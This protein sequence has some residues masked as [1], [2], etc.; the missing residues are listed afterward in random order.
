[1]ALQFANQRVARGR[2][3]TV[4]VLGALMTFAAKKGCR[5]LFG[6]EIITLSGVFRAQESNSS[7]R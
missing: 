5:G 1:M 4:G 6:E 2:R 7:R 3:R